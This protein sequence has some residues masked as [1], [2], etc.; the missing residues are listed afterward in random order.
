MP[1]RAAYSTPMLHV[2][3]LP[4]SIAFYEKLGFELVDFEGERATPYWARMHVEG[5]AIM[6][7]AAEEGETIHPIM[8]YLYT[9]DLPALRE[10]LVASGLNVPDIKR[11]PYMP[12][13]E[14]ALRDP[15]GNYVL[16]GHWSKAEDDDWHRRRRAKGFS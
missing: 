13:G 7:L 2:A 4:R 8:L 5:G 16:V 12:S 6:F 11:P 10:H 9:P 3:D 14:L 1:P 15:D